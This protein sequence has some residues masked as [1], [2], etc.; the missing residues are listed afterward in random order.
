MSICSLPPRYLD[1]KGLV[2][3]RGEALLAQKVLEC[4]TRGYRNHPQFDR[5]KAAANPLADVAAPQTH[6]L[7]SV[8]PGPIEDWEIR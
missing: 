3:L 5:F 7:F 6:P 4:D 8:L 1:A 2:A